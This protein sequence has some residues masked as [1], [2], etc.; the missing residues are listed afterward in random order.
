MTP[1]DTRT[2]WVLEQMVLPALKQGGYSYNTQVRVG[3]RLGHGSHVVDAIADK[4]GAQI[5]ISLKWQQT[6]STAEQKV[7]FEVICLAE[8]MHAGDYQ[9]AYLVLG[10]EGWS[11]RQFY[12]TGGLARHLT[13]ATLVDTSRSRISSRERIRVGYRRVRF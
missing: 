10:S 9:R 13:S 3:N 8:T 1:R 4:D 2:G 6:A 12:T 11:L 7:P 5:L